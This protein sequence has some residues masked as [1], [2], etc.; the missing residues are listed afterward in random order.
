MAVERGFIPG[1][2]QLP[3]SRRSVLIGA[4]SAAGGLAAV[5]VLASIGLRGQDEKPPT[6]ELLDDVLSEESLKRAHI[7]IHQAPETKLYLRK[8]VLQ[9][10]LFQ[11][12][13]G[14]IFDEVDIV[15]IDADKVNVDRQQKMPRD[16]RILLEAAMDKIKDTSH[17]P[18]QDYLGAII[19][20]RNFREIN[21]EFLRQNP[22]FERKV[23]I[24]LAVGGDLK[25]KPEE[26]Y[27]NPK[28]FGRYR[29]SLWGSFGY[30]RRL[31]SESLGF[32][33]NHE[34]HHYNPLGNNHG[35]FETDLLTVNHIAG[36]WKK[37]QETGD[38]TG[39]PFVFATDK[40][41]TIT[42]DLRHNRL[43]NF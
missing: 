20:G 27:P 28:Q 37:F 4:V 33:L 18:S 6:R 17:D 25:P 5:R 42:A 16:A 8:E 11:D 12:S 13:L 39:Y 14:G 30:D 7:K 26:S 1:K 15:L 34:I 22:E 41:I 3:I 23:Y 9:F 2:W 38:T 32:I 31:T 24:Y 21:P 35:E 43:S 19:I 10:P 29:N 40:G 36:A